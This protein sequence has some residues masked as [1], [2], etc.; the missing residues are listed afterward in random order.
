MLKWLPLLALATAGLFLWFVAAFMADNNNAWTTSEPV[1]ILT[2]FGTLAGL[3]AMLA[4]VT[5]G[6]GRAFRRRR[7]TR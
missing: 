4:I 2:G 5:L 3:V 7:S 6:V 1:Q